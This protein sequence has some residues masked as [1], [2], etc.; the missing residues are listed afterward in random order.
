MA[1]G[2]TTVTGRALACAGFTGATVVGLRFAGAGFLTFLLLG[3]ARRPF[4]P[5]HRE[6]WPLL[7]AG[8]GFAITSQLFFS[9]LQR[10][11]AG[12]VALLFYAFP[13]VVTFIEM[14]SGRR[15]PRM[16][17]VALVLALVGV[18][19]IISPSGQLPI[20]LPGIGFAL[21]SAVTYGTSLL[22]SDRAVRN[23]NPLTKAA[24]VC[25]IVGGGNLL[26]GICRGAIMAPGNYLPLFILNSIASM[27]T[28]TL[29]FLGMRY[30]GP[31]RAGIVMTLEAISAVIF[32]WVFLAE[33]C[34]ARQALGGLIVLGAALIIAASGN[35]PETR[36]AAT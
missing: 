11:T 20:S 22:V 18:V 12:I 6:R 9:A 32:G 8:L 3:L 26:P 19:V 27:A 4:R 33:A 14:L 36:P 13:A 34:G 28:I 23:T 24:W 15:P 10:G 21:A 16:V 5:A 29:V 30:I 17:I 2:I 31:A 7:W 1:Y 25:V 35:P